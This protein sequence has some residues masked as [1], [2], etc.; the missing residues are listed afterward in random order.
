MGASSSKC[1][2]Q[3]TMKIP[4]KVKIHS[5]IL[6]SSKSCHIDLNN[7]TIILLLDLF[8]SSHRNAHLLSMDP[9]H[10]VKKL[11]SSIKSGAVHGTKGL[12]KEVYYMVIAALYRNRRREKKVVN[13]ARD[14]HLFFKETVL[15]EDLDAFLIR[16]KFNI[17]Y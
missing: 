16:Q 10:N 13:I 4:A 11:R 6:R 5:Y 17:P 9:R 2:K 8:L 12:F 3:A 1:F 15:D 14:L 7:K